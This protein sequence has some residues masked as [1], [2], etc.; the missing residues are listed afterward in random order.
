MNDASNLPLTTQILSDANHV[1]LYLRVNMLSEIT[2]HT[3]T[4]ILPSFYTRPEPDTSP[5]NPSGSTLT[6]PHQQCP[7][8]RAWKAWQSV[9]TRLYLKTESMDLSK[10]LGP[11]LTDNCDTEW[12]WPWK[13]CPTTLHLYRCNGSWW[14]MYLPTWHTR[15][16]LQY[17]QPADNH[18]IPPM[19][20]IPVNVAIPQPD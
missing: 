16:F 2:D 5:H 11:W 19:K 18:T 15:T 13:L 7:G 20:A 14:S 17:M 4:T 9:I 12:N 3:G 10:K 1:R 8:K 6:W